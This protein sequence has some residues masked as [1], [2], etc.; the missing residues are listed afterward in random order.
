MHRCSFDA[1]TI[2]QSLIILGHDL[3]DT[4][5]GCTDKVLDLGALTVK[6]GEYDYLLLLELSEVFGNNHVGVRVGVVQLH[7]VLVLS[8]VVGY[9]AL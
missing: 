1:D 5:C 8:K 2:H 7:H 3:L 6:V 4:V 9:F